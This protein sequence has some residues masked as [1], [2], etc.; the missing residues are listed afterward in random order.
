[1][2]TLTIDQLTDLDI[3]L[4][5]ARDLYEKHGKQSVVIKNF[6]ESLSEKQRRLWWLWVGTICVDV[7]DTKDDFHNQAK[8]RI[9]L[10]IF[11]RN[12]ENHQGLCDAVATMKGIRGKA[13]AQEY[14]MIRKYIVDHI[15]HMDATTSEMREALKQLES[16]AISLGIVLPKPEYLYHMAI[17]G[18]KK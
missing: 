2:R 15:S 4:R 18:C 12:P 10:P 9:F 16:E 7:G 1:M 3:V 13:T 8:E 11:L 14:A 6:D 5:V 17:H